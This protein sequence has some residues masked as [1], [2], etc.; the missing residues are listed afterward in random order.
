[1]NGRTGGATISTWASQEVAIRVL[2][3]VASRCDRA[4]IPILPVKGVVT[5]RVLYEDVAERP[6]TDV[7][8]RIRP[9]DFWRWRGVADQAGWRCWNAVWTYGVRNY[10]IAS[11]PLDVESAIGPPGMCGLTVDEMLARS[12]E[13]ELARD[14]RVRV[15]EIHD[16]A[17]LLAVNAYR[18]WFVLGN[19]HS[20]MD[21]DRIARAP[22]FC[23]EAFVERAL[24]S[25]IATIAWIV[26][27]W[28]EASYANDAWGAIRKAIQRRAAV[29]RLSAAVYRR[30]A[31]TRL[32][33]TI[34]APL[35]QI[36]CIDGLAHR[37]RALA[38][39]TAWLAERW[40]RGRAHVRGRG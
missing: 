36:S 8:V 3:D 32:V 13:M 24:K 33:G 10:T 5:A 34:P 29:R 11:L 12:R 20:R 25:R 4:G 39:T 28:I 17:V 27:G 30:V 26:A 6:I 1:M 18:D 23:P 15:P 9:R 2:R 14:L 38:T 37:G 21:L 31:A 7:D 40:V 35:L 16:H 22:D 19:P